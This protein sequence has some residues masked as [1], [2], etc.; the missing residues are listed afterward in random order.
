MLY[1]GGAAEGC[2]HN[3]G[4]ADCP[5]LCLVLHGDVFLRSNAFGDTDV[6]ARLFA[7]DPEPVRDDT[8]R[9]GCL[10]CKQDV[11]E[12]RCRPATAERGW[13]R[14]CMTLNRNTQEEPR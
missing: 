6:L 3:G 1:L 14:Y 4:T 2:R 13:W 5:P 7:P 12:S 9:V 8:P 11:E 10:D